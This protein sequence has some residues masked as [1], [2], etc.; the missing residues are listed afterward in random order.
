[1]N[2]LNFWEW[3]YS[4]FV[5]FHGQYEVNYQPIS[6][7]NFKKEI[8]DAYRK[9]MHLM[10]ASIVG[11]FPVFEYVLHL[12]RITL[13]LYHLDVEVLEKSHDT[14][15]NIWLLPDS[16][17]LK[18]DLR[19][20]HPTGIFLE[21]ECLPEAI[22]HGKNMEALL[23]AHWGKDLNEI[24]L[25]EHWRILRDREN[26]GKEKLLD[27]DR[28]PLL[29][30]ELLKA[31][32]Q[33]NLSRQI[34]QWEEIL[35]RMKKTKNIELECF[36][37]QKIHS[38][39]V[40][41]LTNFSAKGHIDIVK[42]KYDEE[43][44]KVY[45]QTSPHVVLIYPGISPIQ[46][47]Y[48]KRS[49]QLAEEE[50]QCLRIVGVHRAIAKD[51]VVVELPC[52]SPEL[53]RELNEL[54]H[55]CKENRVNGGKILRSL[56]K[57][58]KL[59][60]KQMTEE[61]RL[62]LAS[63]KSITAFTDF[64]LG[65]AVMEEGIDPLLC[66][67]NIS[68]H[69]L[70]PLTR[71]LMFEIEKH[72]QIYFGAKCRVGFL[73]CIPKTKENS[74][75]RGISDRTFFELKKLSGEYE[76]FQVVYGEAMDVPSLR[77]S[78]RDMGP[79]D[80]LYIS[81]H[82]F[83]DPRHNASGLYI[84]EELWFGDENDLRVPSVVFLS[85]CHTAPRGA[86]AVN[87]ADLFLR[88]GA[89]AVL[90]SF[91]PINAYRNMLLMIRLFTYILEA[92]RGSKQ[93]K[94]LAD[95]WTGVVATNAIHELIYDAPRLKQWMHN[96]GTNGVPRII[97]FQLRRS[98]DRLRLGTT[99]RDTI[100]LLKEMLRDEGMEG[101]FD[102]VL[103]GNNYFPESFFYQIIGYPENIFLYNDV[104]AEYLAAEMK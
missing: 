78:L 55:F 58:G 57:I 83:Y 69:P 25:K 39:H 102:D 37:V 52:A 19:T 93:Y 6:W 22:E 45:S 77:A 62:I 26:P 61:Q 75:V 48:G 24:L 100:A 72:R 70:T 101:K 79:M 59:F 76:N 34:G 91:I 98:V 28:Q 97:D 74:Y 9:F 42:E 33:G 12:P 4:Y 65:L 95:A 38:S 68:Y 17:F 15:H 94:T 13:D 64:P 31:L 63:A 3:L 71:G 5:I 43:W 8:P 85:A 50:K 96:V 1:M 81:A 84:G 23:S 18:M 54:E 11:A 40:Q 51:G 88:M 7:L 2:D 16:L 27:V 10:D 82:G 29:Q 86:G 53:F 41:T 67:K 35:S 14:S 87:S 66:F 21:D 46:V 20:M 49:P 90:C 103:S 92:Q 47:K 89:E 99:Y 30:G 104:F 44:E 73:E 56:R 60:E 80:I 32:P 36:Q